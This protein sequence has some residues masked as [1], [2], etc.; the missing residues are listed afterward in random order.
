MDA[1]SRA[2]TRISDHRFLHLIAW[3]GRLLGW[4][5]RLNV[6]IAIVL[7]I[8]AAALPCMWR[9]AIEPEPLSLSVQAV[10]DW[11]GLLL[12]G[13]PLHSARRTLTDLSFCYILLHICGYITVGFAILL[14]PG[15]AAAGVARDRRTGRLD[16]LVSTTFSST[17]IY[18][19]KVVAAG[20]P[21][22][23]SGCF[24]YLLMLPV[25]F[26][27][28]LDATSVFRILIEMLFQVALV[29]L[30]SVTS[31]CLCRQAAT[32]RVLAYLAVWILLPLV[33]FGIVAMGNKSRYHGVGSYPIQW[34]D[35]GW[36]WTWRQ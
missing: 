12:L 19:A 8:V 16:D 3:E 4:G 27:E 7:L 13:T 22:W 6:R 17:A 24:V 15:I 23:L 33:W 14:L 18:L 29:S 28:R 31:S 20:L 21:F 2:G 35:S 5:R 36:Q 32:A 25:M 30:F 26:A 34:P 1:D 10:C 9:F 11:A